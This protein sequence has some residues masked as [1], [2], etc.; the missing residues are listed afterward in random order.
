MHDLDAY[1]LGGV[2]R[3]AAAQSHEPVAAL[4]A[5]EGTRLPDE[6]DVRVRPNPVE[7]EGVFQAFER[8][9]G[10]PGGDYAPVG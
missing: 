1:P 3:A 7:N 4:L 8:R 6:L 9:V 10:E 2:H 5:V